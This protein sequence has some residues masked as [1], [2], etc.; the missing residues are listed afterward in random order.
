M[1]FYTDNLGVK[2]NLNVDMPRKQRNQIKDVMKR[3]QWVHIKKKV[4]HVATEIVSLTL[5][6]TLK[7]PTGTVLRRG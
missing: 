7:L 6:L 3:C 1:F 4:R 5:L 2:S